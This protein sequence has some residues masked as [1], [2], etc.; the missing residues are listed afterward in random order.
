MNDITKLPKWA[1]REIERLAANVAYW[2][3]IATAG[4][5]TSNTKVRR[6]GGDTYLGDSPRIEFMLDDGTTIEAHTTGGGLRVSSSMGRGIN[7]LPQASNSILVEVR[8][9]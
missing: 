3:A 4:P 2:E 9:R 8:S 5:E 6:H 1:Q 7:V